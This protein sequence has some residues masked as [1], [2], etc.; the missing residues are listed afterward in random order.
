MAMAE[1]LWGAAC[2]GDIEALKNY[3]E[4]G[5]AANIRHQ[6]FGREH[7]LVMG[8]FRNNQWETVDYLISIGAVVTDE[9]KEEIQTEL[10]RVKYMEILSQ[11]ES[12]LLKPY[13]GFTIEK[14]CHT[15]PDGTIKK[16]TVIYTA[17]DRE[18]DV[19][20]G[21]GTLAG[22]KKKIDSYTA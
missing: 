6:K 4:S 8:A 13:K 3:F 16:D 17:Y 18:G 22:L 21:A 2:S 5:A 7:S 15:N 11:T 1:E 9:E 12:K 14:S 19:H 20:D 10:N